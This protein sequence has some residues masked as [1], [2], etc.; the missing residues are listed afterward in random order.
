MTKKIIAILM[1]LVTSVCLMVSLTASTYGEFI[2][3][4][5]SNTDDSSLSGVHPSSS[6]TRGTSAPSQNWN[7]EVDGKYSFHGK[8][9]SATD[10]YTDYRFAG[11]PSGL[12]TINLKNMHSDYK[13]VAKACRASD[14]KTLKTFTVKVGETQT[15]AF[16]TTSVW[17]LKICGSSN[18]EGYVE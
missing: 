18:F 4:S 9:S 15:F 8:S 3:P 13:L 14:G 12:Y 7:F 6:T 2:E 1:A 5:S 11:A 17:Y 16:S 10:L